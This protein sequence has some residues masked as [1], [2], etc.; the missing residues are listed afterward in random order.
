MYPLLRTI[1]KPVWLAFAL[2]VL[3]CAPVLAGLAR[4]AG[5]VSGRPEPVALIRLLLVYVTGELAVLLR[6]A[7]A[8]EYRIHQVT[9]FLDEV[10]STALRT[11]DLDVHFTADAEASAVLERRERP[12]LVFSRHAGPGDSVLLVHMLLAKYGRE[13][14]IVMKEILT[15]DPVV[16]H[17]ARHL[18]SALIDNAV[19]DA[20]EI[21]DVGRDLGPAGALLLFPEGGN[22]TPERR[23]RAIDWLR[24]NGEPERAA[25]AEALEH[26]FA[27]RPRG[28]LAALAG[29][30]HADVIFSA[31]TG[32][33]RA[34]SGLSLLTELP[35]DTTIQV[36][37]WH[38]PHDTV[39]AGEAA[40]VAWLD[41][42][43]ARLDAWV[44]AQGAE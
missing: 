4:L 22:F 7:A 42:W 16:G 24:R 27:P 11:L 31:H 10:V 14:G 28:A 12:V 32:L 21:R 43:W 30:P 20:D 29:A 38:V 35:R 17:I 5:R 39:P 25:R 9:T 26:M 41:D 18:P 19:D 44:E 33:G 6:P 15:L 23:A 1:V 34:A 40:R 8:H 13:P 36:R 37:L 3:A 2:A